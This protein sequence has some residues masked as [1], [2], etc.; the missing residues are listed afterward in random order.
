MDGLPGLGGNLLTNQASSR[1]NNLLIKQG[2]ELDDEIFT[3]GE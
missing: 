1:F 3:C 2:L